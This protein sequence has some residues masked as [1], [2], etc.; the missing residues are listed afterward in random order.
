[1]I[2]A[3]IIIVVLVLALPFLLFAS[4]AA[5]AAAMG[6]ALKSDAEQRYEGSELI[7]LNT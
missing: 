4:G 2:G 7:D 1:V 6:W 3:V 5:V